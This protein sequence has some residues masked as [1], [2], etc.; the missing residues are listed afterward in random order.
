MMIKINYIDHTGSTFEIGASEGETLM[1]AATNNLIP[2]IDGDCGGNCACGTCHVIIDENWTGRLDS[3]NSEEIS[4]LQMT[5][6]FNEHSR[7]ACQIVITKE[8]HGIVVNLP[9]HQM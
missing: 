9:E 5:P 3:Q 7:L 6:D 2:G 4:L 1:S 8:L